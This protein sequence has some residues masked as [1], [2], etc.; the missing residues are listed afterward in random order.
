MTEEQREKFVGKDASEAFVIRLFDGLARGIHATAKQKGWWDED[1]EDGTLIALMHSELS[2]G[3]EGLRKG[4]PPSDKIPDFSAIE[5]ELADVIIRILDTA[6][7][8]GWNVGAALMAKLNYNDGR[9][10]KH[11][12]KE[13]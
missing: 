8:R 4:N 10:Y 13:F 3:L 5:E 12:G 11:G 9:S 6:A 2:E 7:A 1:R